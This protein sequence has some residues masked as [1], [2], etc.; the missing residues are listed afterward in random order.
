MSLIFFWLN[1]ETYL[2]LSS[3]RTTD[4]Y[5]VHL[6]ETAGFTM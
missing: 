2:P 1:A 5:A 4:Q 6:L 3:T